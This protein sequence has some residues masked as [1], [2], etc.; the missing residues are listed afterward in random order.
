MK[1]R[2]SKIIGT[3]VV[4]I[5]AAASWASPAEGK[6][7]RKGGAPAGNA[8]VRT[9]VDD[10][11]SGLQLE[12]T[13]QLIPARERYVRCSKAACG[14]PLRDECTTRFTQLD[15]EIPSVVPIATDAEG[16]P[17]FDVEVKMDGQLL[18]T[19]L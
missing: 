18:T 14:S 1:S 19:K 17:R 3:T 7:K 10:Y 15:S 5:L 8:V 6:G 11:K 4:V 2:R 16:A 12:E 13:G 9:C